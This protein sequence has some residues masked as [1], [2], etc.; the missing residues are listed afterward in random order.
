M[1]LAFRGGGGNACGANHRMLRV[2]AV[3]MAGTGLERIV[4]VAGR[5]EGARRAHRVAVAQRRAEAGTSIEGWPIMGCRWVLRLGHTMSRR[6]PPQ[7]DALWFRCRSLSLRRIVPIVVLLGVVPCLGRVGRPEAVR[8]GRHEVI[9]VWI[10]FVVVVK[11]VGVTGPPRGLL[12]VA[13]ASL[14]GAEQ[15]RE[16]LRPSMPCGSVPAAER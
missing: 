7:V 3:W 8:H 11:D 9:L 6:H 10:N 5:C 16:P 15:S 1:R 14:H 12:A 4:Q 13:I 2:H